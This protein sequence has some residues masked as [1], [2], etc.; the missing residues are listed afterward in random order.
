MRSLVISISGEYDFS[1]SFM[2]LAYDL[3]H[4]IYTQGVMSEIHRTLADELQIPQ[5]GGGLEESVDLFLLSINDFSELLKSS[6]SAN[7]STFRRGIALSVSEL[8]QAKEYEIS[9]L[10][11][12]G[13]SFIQLDTVSLDLHH[14]ENGADIYQKI[15]TAALT[16]LGIVISEIAQN[17]LSPQQRHKRELP[18][19]VD[20]RKLRAWHYSNDT[21]QNFQSNNASL[22]EAFQESVFKQQNN[23][24]IEFQDES[25]TYRQ[26]YN[27]SR[28]FA[29]TIQENLTSLDSKNPSVVALALPKS[30]ELYAAILGILSLGATYVPIDPEYPEERISNIIRSAKPSLL[31]KCSSA[32]I[33]SDLDIVILDS[34]DIKYDCDIYIDERVSTAKNVTQQTAVIIYT[35][36]STGMPKGVQLSH[37]NILHFCQWYIHHVD[38][39]EQ[40]KALQFT[41]VSFDASLLDIFP[42]LFVGARLIV[43]SNEQRHDFSSLDNLIV[44]HN[45]THSFIPPAMLG[46]LP[47]YQW[48]SMSHIV[49]GGD[50]CDAKTIKQWSSGRSLHNI[51]GPTECTVLATTE[52]FTT[53]SNNKIIGKPIANT[54]VYLLNDHFVPVE[55]GEHGE[56][57]ISGPGV[58]AGYYDAPNMTAERYV[59]LNLYDDHREIAYKTGD[60]CYWDDQGRIN[61]VGRKDNQLKIRGFRVELG[62]IENVIID[63]DL[64]KT[65]VV[66]ANDKKQIRAFVTQPSGDVDVA[67]L[68]AVL[69]NTLPPYMLPKHIMV[70]D[71]FPST[72][73]GKID[74][75]ALICLPIPSNVQTETEVLSETE[76][77]LRTIWA[78]TLSIDDIDI[79]KRESFFNLGGHSLLVS[80]M[81]LSVKNQFE[82]GFTLARF[83]ENPTIEALASLILDDDLQKGDQISDRIYSDMVLDSEIRPCKEENAD[84]FSPK[85]ILLTGANGFLGVHLLEELISQTGATIHCLVRASSEE[86]AYKKLYDAYQKYN[87]KSLIG[88]PRIKAIIGDLELPMLGLSESV[89]VQLCA[90][91]DVIYHN[92]AQ[93]NHIY[94]Y[95]YLY[96]SNVRSTFDLLRIATT[97]KNK[98]FVFVSTLSAASNIDCNDRLVEEGPAEQLPAFV[99]NGYNLTKWVSE[100]LVWQAYKRGLPV[101]LVRP[102]NICGHSKTGHCYPDKNRILLLLKG[103]AQMGYAPDWD[104]TFDLCPVDF[105]AKGIVAA[106]TEA[107]AHTPVLHF[108]NPMPLSWSDYV[109]RLNHHNIPIKMIPAADWRKKLLKL[110]ESN[111]LFN[112]IS[113]YLDETS[114]D[115]SDISSID[116]THTLNRLKQFNMAYPKK[117]NSLIDANLGFLIRSKFIIPERQEQDAIQG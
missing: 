70:L 24:A 86:Y 2:S 31:V 51:Y 41:T 113:F 62:E 108:H 25:L 97:T 45:V 75:K 4:V 14:L 96:E 10:Q 54:K 1:P 7:P 59:K 65:C 77:K 90:K 84:I 73:N 103:S 63:T 111:A 57:Y 117:D 102:G 93:V 3:G 98:Q 64:Y 28:Q 91:I 114:E 18:Q 32:R 95:N 37:Q 12:A 43:P 105:I 112:I 38:L 60:T 92:G 5:L 20:V 40:S 36:G 68:E 66:I 27:A 115:I 83:M 44:N 58:G 30:I 13:N 71:E 101:T 19:Q 79:S 39:C 82:G 106:T 23:I 9:W 6:K 76:S 99:N 42:T 85:E 11:C 61:F 17:S 89:F 56:L 34:N 69:S 21:E 26:L 22:F 104:A 67:Q 33:A 48:P 81:L 15:Q 116:Y 47:N 110:D 52:K 29:Y 87:V 107:R 50:V 100:L 74:R 88:S 49:T 72:V 16:S 94:D 109:G 53:A 80:K 55:T 78:D 46:A 35:S 8:P